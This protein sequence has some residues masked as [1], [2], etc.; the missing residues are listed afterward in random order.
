M[1]TSRVE[2]L[3]RGERGQA[4]VELSIVLPFLLFFM[5]FSVDLG[6][7]VN[8]YLTLSKIAYETSRLAAR[9]ADVEILGAPE[10][11]GGVAL[12]QVP[13]AF[14]LQVGAVLTRYEVA[15]ADV[16]VWTTFDPAERSVNIRVTK[17]VQLFSPIKFIL[18]GA[19]GVLPVRA[20][21]SGPFLFP[22]SV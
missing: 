2:T 7:A 8:E 10:H 19:G 17:D 3:A 16:Q 22:D 14:K 21:I 1:M 15:A 12:A 20:E 18:G 5:V 11:V 9:T 6:R 4:L 13:T